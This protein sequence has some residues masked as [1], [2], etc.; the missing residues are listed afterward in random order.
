MELQVTNIIKKAIAEMT[1][2]SWQASAAQLSAS[3]D[4]VREYLQEKTSSQIEEIIGKLSQNIPLSVED[5]GLIESWIV[6]DAESYM[7]MENDCNSWIEESKRLSTTL[8]TFENK[9][10][11]LEELFKLSGILEDAIRNSYDI[12]NFL[13]KKERIQKFKSA[14]SDGLDED[15]KNI[16]IEVLNGKLRS[17]DY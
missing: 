11:T 7:Q 2:D 16:L 10:C 1:D 13:E 9:E 17:T 14:V 3:K 12:A 5:I 6:G 4:A 8:Q 15:E